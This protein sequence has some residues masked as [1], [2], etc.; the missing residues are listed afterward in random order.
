MTAQ[1][2]IRQAEVLLPGVM[3]PEGETDPRWQAIIAIADFI[4]SE[5]LAVWEFTERWGAYE[6]DDLQSAVATCLLE[7]LMEHH[8]ELLFPRIEAA[9]RASP[10]FMRTLAMCWK[11]GQS[12]HPANAAKIDKVIEE[13]AE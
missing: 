10:V 7:H 3:A 1:E 11:F 8:F 9:A 13:A 2:A 6:D 5:P 4:E 12:T